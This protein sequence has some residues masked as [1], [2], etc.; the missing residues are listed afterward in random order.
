MPTNWDSVTISATASTATD[1]EYWYDGTNGRLTSIN[2]KDT[3]FLLGQAPERAAPTTAVSC[4]S[5]N[6][7]FWFDSTNHIPSFKDNNSGTVSSTVVPDTGASNNFLTAISA[8]GVISK[9][10]PSFSNISGTATTGQLPGSGATTVNGQTCTLGSTCTIP[11]SAVNAQ[12]T[13][14]QVLA[15]DFSNYKTITV[16]SGTFTI[17]LVASGS[18]PAAGQYIDIINYGSGVVTVARSGQNINGGTTSLT[19]QSASAT[20]PN[21]MRVIS[22]GTNYFAGG[23]F[24]NPMTTAGDIMYGGTTG[25]PTRLATGTAKQLF[26]AGSTPSYIDFPEHLIIPAAN[27]N[28]A[29]AGA[30]F[31]IPASNAPTVACRAGTNNLG[32]VLQ[33]ANNNTSTNA[34]FTVQL[35]NDW[36]TA[37]QP[38]INIIYGSGSN[39]SGTVK[40]TFSSACTKADGSVSDDPSFNAESATTGKTMAV[41]NRMWAESTQFTAVTSG[42]N[43]I[44]GSTMIVKVTSGNGTASSTVNVS[45]VTITIP[46]LLTVQAN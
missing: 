34:Q 33:W 13:T 23:G 45:Q 36:D 15:A 8:S 18:Q 11:L 1:V 46:R 19:M 40:W 43:C 2:G 20:I 12:T 42:N 38:Y 37:V 6:G 9:A 30:G 25:L 3:P 26:I 14:Y 24:T 31:S 4:G 28:N 29:T 41:A 44:A 32:G 10:Q 27:C 21:R 5:G 17:T 22:D 16:A 7:C 39:T 35:P